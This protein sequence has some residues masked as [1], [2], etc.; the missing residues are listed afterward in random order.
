MF[1]YKTVVCFISEHTKIDQDNEVREI[2]GGE[3][4]TFLFS[5][6]GCD[7]FTQLNTS[8]LIL[9]NRKSV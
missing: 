5:A 1:Q 3:W 6:G 7:H 8:S 4:G 9:G 2:Q